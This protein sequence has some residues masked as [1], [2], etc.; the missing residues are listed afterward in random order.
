[1]FTPRS[2]APV[3][4]SPKSR[5]RRIIFWSAIGGA[6]VVG[7]LI[8]ISL[9]LLHPSR[10]K[11]RVESL[12][13]ERLNLAV[14]IDEISVSF[15]PRPRIAGRGMVF[16]FPGRD[17]L[18]PF[19]DVGAFWMDIGLL[20]ALRRHV[21]TVH[22]DDMTISVPPDRDRP[23]LGPD[24]ATAADEGAAPEPGATPPSSDGVV[25][26]HLIS[27]NATL[28]F[29]PGKPTDTPLVFVV[30]DLALE[31]VGFERAITFRAKLTNPIPRGVVETEGT[32]GP[33]RRDLPQA[34]AIAGKY[35]F[36][37]ADLSTIN[38]IG[39]RL[40]STGTYDGRLTAIHAKGTTNTPDFSLD[41]GG[42][43]VPL[44][45]SYIATIDGTSGTTR[46]DRVDA[47]LGQTAIFASG[48]IT[49]LPGPDGHDIKLNYA[50]TDGRIEDVLRLA[51]D[52][53]TA[54]MTGEIALQGTLA[55]PPGRGPVR[56][57]LQLAGSFGL[58]DAR[59]SDG[60]VQQKLR[61]FSRRSQGIKKEDGAAMPRVMSDF[62][63]RFALA[64]GVLSFR[65]LAF[66]VPGADVR[67][68][69]SYRIE[70]AE[71]DFRGNLRMKATVSKAMGGVKSI[72]LKPFDFI[73][74][75]DG[76]G[77]VVPIKITGTRDAPKMGIE[78]GRVFGGGEKEKKAAPV[79]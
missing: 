21:E 78:F 18:P 23:A 11:P 46:L 20:S 32:F 61:E 45:A 10:L 35:V 8:A 51:M 73:F 5:L 33:W 27:H 37:G 14:T 19:I 28:R 38:G 4:R 76:A 41:L 9:V 24:P 72:F 3:A 79:K 29:L 56:R 22:L 26:D 55:L 69:G 67:L 1:M 34:V 39:G 36:T 30:H 42:S 70:G 6:A 74:R 44:Q 66:Q 63:G 71:I 62:R 13:S 48:I 59:F 17:D 31:D 40:G 15:L 65:E 57:R 58:D 77:A 75:K 43:P 52:K 53:P 60:E 2:P 64:G 54:M 16:R 7:V 25:V 47:V 12:L 68:A 50:I 49:N